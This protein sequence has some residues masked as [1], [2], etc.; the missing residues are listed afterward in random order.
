MKGAMDEKQLGHRTSCKETVWS[1]KIR[2]GRRAR[3]Y[4]EE[5]ARL[6]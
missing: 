5:Q 3:V 2:V 1:V 6:R 4:S